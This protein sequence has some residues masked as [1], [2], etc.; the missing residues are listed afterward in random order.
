MSLTLQVGWGQRIVGLAVFVACI[1]LAAWMRFDLPW[2]TWVVL[3]V[4][5]V[6]AGVSSVSNFGERL[7]ASDEGLRWENVLLRRERRAAWAEVLSALELDR[8]TLFLTVEGQ[9]R[10]VL[11][12][13]D[14][15]DLLM[16]LLQERGVSVEQR[17]RP[18]LRDLGR[19]SRN[20]PPA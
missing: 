9:R 19:G 2:P 17:M 12:A 7:H 3:G 11:D 18:R 16:K 14:G 6:A 10:W 15:H 8:R 4:F 1:A 5:F 13:F 20:P